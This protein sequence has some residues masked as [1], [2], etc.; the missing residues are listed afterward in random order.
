VVRI[1]WRASSYDSVGSQKPITAYAIWRR[2][3]ANSLASGAPLLMYPPGEWD[4]VA[5]VPA[6]CEK[7]YSTLV[8][9]LGDSTIASG[10]HY[11]VFFIRALT[12][13]PGDYLDSPV[14]SGYSVD[15]L[16]P[17]E[18]TG[19][20]GA[21]VANGLRISWKPSV[22]SDFHHYLLF[23]GTCSNDPAPSL[24]ATLAGTSCV[25]EAWT[26]EDSR[27]YYT[28]RAVD[29]SGNTSSC[30][31]LAPSVIVATLLQSFSLKA[32]GQAVEL[33]W[34]LSQCEENVEF[35][36][37]R[38][39]GTGSE[40]EKLTAARPSRSGLDFAYRDAACVPGTAY[41]YRVEYSDGSKTVSLF[42]TGRIM[43]PA[44]RLT[45][46]QNQPNPFNPSTTIRYYLPERMRVL[47]EIYDTSGRLVARLVDDEQERGDKAVR[48]DGRGIRGNAVSSG[49]YYYRLRAGK[50][51]VS[52][53][54]VLL[55]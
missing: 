48:W 25:D 26:P 41:R 22:E 16:P 1:K 24:F 47:L 14:D 27:Y 3:D 17:V 19:L 2:I 50:D 8:P 40:F 9:T 52:R 55:K 20:R 6:C 29:R 35:M 32:I 33:A 36:I 46:Y 13:T 37:S 10:M 21:Q 18:P 5:S 44:M 7:T 28:L 53:K 54:M 38:A 49:V 12:A 43:T 31:E 45:L 39:E 42:E 4:Y 11:S 23:K 30:A 34:R 15:N 51:I